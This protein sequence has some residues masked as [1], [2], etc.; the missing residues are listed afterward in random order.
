MP[1]PAPD[2]MPP[3]LPDAMPPPAPDAASAPDAALAPDAAPATPDA[4]PVDASDSD[5]TTVPPDASGPLDATGPAID[6]STAVAEGGGCGCRTAPRAPDAALALVGLAIALFPAR[7]R[8][9]A[10]GKIGARR[11]A[12]EG[13]LGHAIHI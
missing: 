7:R 11:E 3:P 8:R 5:A 12:V 2:A 9:R 1:P 13:D 10:R 4:A 6:A